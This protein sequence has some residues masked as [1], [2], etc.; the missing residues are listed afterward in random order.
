MTSD[1]EREAIVSRAYDDVVRSGAYS[2]RRF[3]KTVLAPV[4]HLSTAP[5]ARVDE[6]WA[7]AR[8]DDRRALRRTMLNSYVLFP[9]KRLAR[10]TLPATVL[11]SL[12]RLR[13]TAAAG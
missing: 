13:H 4:A 5:D 9:A 1:R 7:R 11:E 3:V 2:Y 8:R 6:L 12:R 10:A